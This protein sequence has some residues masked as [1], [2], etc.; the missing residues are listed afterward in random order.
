MC[1]S[2]VWAS[3]NVWYIAGP[4]DQDGNI[5]VFKSEDDLQEEAKSAAPMDQLSG[6]SRAGFGHN[7]G[8]IREVLDCT[9]SQ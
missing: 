4:P 3:E 9:Y 1:W 5:A 6:S 7:S 2:E 8:H